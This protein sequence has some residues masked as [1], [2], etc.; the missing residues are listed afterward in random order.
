MLRQFVFCS[1]LIAIILNT[2]CTQEY[3]CPTP[4][5]VPCLLPS[6]SNGLVAYFPFNGNANDESGYL[7]NVIFNNATLTSDRNGRK[8]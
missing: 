8:K 4:E 5:P 3:T 2:S 6:L 7:N 1:I